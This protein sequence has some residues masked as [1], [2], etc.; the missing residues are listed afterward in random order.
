MLCQTLFYN[1]MHINLLNPHKKSKRGKY[2]RKMWAEIDIDLFCVMEL[3]GNWWRWFQRKLVK[4]SL[5]KYFSNFNC[6]PLRVE[7]HY[8]FRQGCHIQSLPQLW[9]EFYYHVENKVNV[10]MTEKCC[11]VTWS[12]IPA[13]CLWRILKFDLLSSNSRGSRQYVYIYLY[14]L[15][16][17]LSIVS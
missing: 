3:I 12:T 2:F 17:C 11:W 16:I 4:I 9:E 15:S 5:G 6:N 7:V 13:F 14:L 8:S 1:F 10:L